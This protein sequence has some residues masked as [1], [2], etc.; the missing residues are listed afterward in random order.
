MLISVSFSLKHNVL[1]YCLYPEMFLTPQKGC[2]F[3]FL[4]LNQRHIP[5]LYLPIAA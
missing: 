2:V 3:Y 1:P 4:Y 5:Y